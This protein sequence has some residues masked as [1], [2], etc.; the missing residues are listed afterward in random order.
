M[1]VYTASQFD[2]KLLLS[3]IKAIDFVKAGGDIDDFDGIVHS[4]L[5]DKL[6]DIINRQELF[7]IIPIRNTWE[8]KQSNTLS[9]L[10]D[11]ITLLRYAMF[12]SDLSWKDFKKFDVEMADCI[13]SCDRE[14]I[15]QLC[16]KWLLFAD[17]YDCN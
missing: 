13:R 16:V 1:A 7:Y 6:N 15:I 9:I 14:Y 10:N 2:E 8:K 17:Y 5:S 12:T 4:S 11:T 3:T